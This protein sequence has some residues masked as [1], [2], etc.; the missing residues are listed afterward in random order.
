[1]NGN[2]GQPLSCTITARSSG[3]FENVT[4][5]DERD[6]PLVGLLLTT[7]HNN[8][9]THSITTST[10][11]HIPTCSNRLVVLLMIIFSWA[12]NA[13]GSITITG[14]GLMSNLYFCTKM[15]KREYF[16]EWLILFNPVT[17]QYITK[18]GFPMEIK[19][20]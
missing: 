18:G 13:I 2:C 5:W 17:F 14:W 8:W 12:G 3:L 11:V 15:N 19:P 20:T 6:K 7:Q 9:R 10:Y 4:L 16:R 1:M